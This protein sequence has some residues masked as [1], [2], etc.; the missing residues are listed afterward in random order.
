MC[1]ATGG[2]SEALVGP[3][4]PLGFA[5]FEM[6]MLGRGTVQGQ[7]VGQ[8]RDPAELFWVASSGKQ[9]GGSVSHPH[10]DSVGGG[11]LGSGS[12]CGQAR[13]GETTASACSHP[14]VSYA[15]HLPKSARRPNK[16]VRGGAKK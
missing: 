1:S 9:Q 16:Q 7:V 2:H 15:G 13:R 12:G 10:T 11:S 8:L 6:T 14:L 3:V 4:Y 5:Q